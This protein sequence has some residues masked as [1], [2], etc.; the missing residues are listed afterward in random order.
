MTSTPTHPEQIIRKLR[1]STYFGLD[2]SGRMPRSNGDVAPPS[3][4][5]PP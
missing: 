4:T 1:D 3:P 2:S 5:S